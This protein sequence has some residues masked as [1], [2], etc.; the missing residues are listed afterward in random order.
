MAGVGQAGCAERSVAHG[1]WALVLAGGD[2]TR[3]QKLTRE[4]CGEPIPKQYCRRLSGGRSLLELTLTRV[5]H[6]TV[7]DRTIAI[8]NRDHLKVATHQLRGLPHGNVIVQPC[9]R[10]TGPGLV[11]ALEYLARRDR[12]ATI[13]V[14]PSDHF[15]DDDRAFIRYVEQAEAIVRQLPHKV[16]VL[17]I[18]PDRPE[19]GYGYITLSHR[20]CGDA[21]GTAAF[22]V[23]GFLEK[24]AHDRARQ[25]LEAGGVWNSFVMVF[26]LRRML[27][28]IRDVIPAEVHRLDE[29]RERR[30]TLAEIYEEIE[31]WNFS[32][33]V[34]ERIPHQLVVI[35]VEGLHWS[36]WGTRASIERTLM[37]LD[38]RPPWS[39]RK[40]PTAAA[41]RPI[42]AAPGLQGQ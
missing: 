38:R 10:D 30:R 23:G 35:P 31:P 41:A 39:P 17:G 21:A 12:D 33:R 25:I 13:A 26:R 19:S 36:D 11:L 5:R 1:R 42:A 20:V 24:P 27:E 6:F 29:L 3:L 14:F 8:I 2:G 28:L 34:L 40:A 18:R 37:A 4:L 16:V 22:H 7:T 15:V 9:N 32:R